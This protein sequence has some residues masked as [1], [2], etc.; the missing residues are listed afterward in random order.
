MKDGRILSAGMDSK[1]CLWD[2]RAIRADDILGH[3]GSI[4]KVLVDEH[5]IGISSSYDTTLRI[6]DLDTKSDS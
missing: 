1:L 3:Q 4:T 5:N 2:A 6:W